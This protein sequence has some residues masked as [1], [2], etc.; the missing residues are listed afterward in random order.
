MARIY[1]LSKR[2]GVTGYRAVGNEV[3]VYNDGVL[4][5]DPIGLAV[6]GE[7]QLWQWT[8]ENGRKVVTNESSGLVPAFYQA[9]RVDHPEL[10][11]IWYADTEKQQVQVA[12]RA[13]MW[14]EQLEETVYVGANGNIS[15]QGP[16][17]RYQTAVGGAIVT[18]SIPA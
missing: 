2:D 9:V 4:R 7:T 17:V 16:G 14:Q 12:A 18:Y 1:K 11:R 3:G 13:L 5:I 6:D 8:Y 10:G 15:E